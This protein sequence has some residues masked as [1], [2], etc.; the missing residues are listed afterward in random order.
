MASS[1]D[2]MSITDLVETMPQ[3]PDWEA[4]LV[5]HPEAAAEI[6]VARRVRAYVAE[7]KKLSI[8]VPSDFEMR[9]MERIRAERTLLDLLDLGLAGFARAILELLNALFDLLPTSQTVSAL[10]NRSQP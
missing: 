9:L 2:D 7:L 8:V 10:A 6:E 3:G 1:F 5:A 4:W